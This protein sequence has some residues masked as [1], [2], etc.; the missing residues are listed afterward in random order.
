MTK[1]DSNSINA[2]PRLIC[3][4][5]SKVN[6]HLNCSV[7]RAIVIGIL[8]IGLITACKSTQ[9]QER[10][11]PREQES[12]SDGFGKLL[13]Q[14]R[15]QTYYL[16]TSKSY[17]PNRRMPLVLVFHGSRGS[18]RAIADITHFNELADQKGFI[19]VYPDGI[20]HYW[21]EIRRYSS[22]QVDVDNVSFVKALIAHLKQIRNIDSRRIY[23]T[24]FSSGAI[25]TQTL[26]CKLSNRI[27]AFASVAGTL[28]ANIASSCQPQT[29]VSVLML[30]GTGDESVPYV[31][32]KV[33]D[34]RKVVSVP[35]T[36]E[37]W[38]QHNGC[39]SKANSNYGTQVEI[40][41]YLGCRGGSEVIL[42]TVKG[43]G[44]SWPGGTSKNGREKQGNANGV[45]A[46]QVIWDF[47]Q[48]HTLPSN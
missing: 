19:V 12:G 6:T 45:N 34:V 32:G 13:Y 9:A 30:N 40:S 37:L 27:A 38:R 31:G 10:D 1:K 21:N 5:V 26:A 29:P 18:G 7:L 44:H 11:P 20:D 2:Q 47:F 16:H 25:L 39:A 24:G 8:L 4:R 36:A 42:V 23:A 3:C 33:D 48:R 14:G 22:S 43:S 15:F 46:S 17:Q 41:H 35:K 28:P